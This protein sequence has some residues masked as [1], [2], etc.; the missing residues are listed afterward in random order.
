MTGL[1]TVAEFRQDGFLPVVFRVAHTTDCVQ[2][3]IE[4]G[5]PGCTLHP[6]FLGYAGFFAAMSREEA[7]Y[8]A[9]LMR[10]D[11]EHPMVP[12]RLADALKSNVVA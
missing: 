4:F 3:A 12:V 11:T 2:D 1:W 8:Y 10:I 5:E 7:E 6:E 9:R